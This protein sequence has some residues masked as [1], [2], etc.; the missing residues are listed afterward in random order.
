MIYL[1]Y[2]L[3]TQYKVNTPTTNTLLYTRVHIFGC[4]VNIREG[5]LALPITLNINIINN[6]NKMVLKYAKSNIM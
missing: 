3:Y 5:Q 6:Y 1:V 4:I 2:V